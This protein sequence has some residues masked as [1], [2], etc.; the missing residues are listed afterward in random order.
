MKFCFNSIVRKSPKSELGKE[1][2]K[3]ENKSKAKGDEFSFPKYSFPNLR[4][5]CI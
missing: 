5:F 3:V 4:E 2:I 1:V